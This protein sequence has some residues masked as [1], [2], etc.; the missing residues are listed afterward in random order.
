MFPILHLPG[1]CDYRHMPPHPTLPAHFFIGL[2]CYLFVD[3]YD[4]F[5]RSYILVPC[6]L[7]DV[8]LAVH[9]HSV[10]CLSTV[11]TVSFTSIEV[12]EF[13]V[14][15]FLRFCVCIPCCY[16]QTL[17]NIPEAS[18]VECSVYFMISCLTSKSLVHFE[19]ICLYEYF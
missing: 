2:I 6:C 3:L 17:K 4:L 14:V 13:D 12:S 11:R 8:Q 19:L 10:G 7:Y 16:C 1:S 9:S 18:V 15:L 5:C